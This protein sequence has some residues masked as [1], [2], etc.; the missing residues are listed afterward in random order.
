MISAR[1]SPASQCQH[2]RDWIEVQ[3]AVGMRGLDHQALRRRR[4]GGVAVG[5]AE[6]ARQEAA[7]ARRE[8]EAL[9]SHHAAASA[10]AGAPRPPISSHGEGA[11]RVALGIAQPEGQRP[12]TGP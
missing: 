3:D 8:D 6:P 11:H 7:G 1:L 2:A 12:H 10:R 4:D 5:P 9:G